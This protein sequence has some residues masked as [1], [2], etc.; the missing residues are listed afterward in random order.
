MY[1]ILDAGLP[2][3]HDTIAELIP[4]WAL[5]WLFCIFAFLNQVQPDNIS[6]NP[7]GTRLDISLR[8]F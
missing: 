5:I 4:R 3:I 2:E 7:T 1:V 8:K 6:T